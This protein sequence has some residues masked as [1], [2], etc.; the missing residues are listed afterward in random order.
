MDTLR[1]FF[2]SLG[3]ADGKYD[4]ANSAHLTD[5]FIIRSLTS[6]IQLDSLGISLVGRRHDD[7]SCL[8]VRLILN[9]AKG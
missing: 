5:Y 4:T 8:M 9:V 6:R 3:C 7:G 2:H 1:I